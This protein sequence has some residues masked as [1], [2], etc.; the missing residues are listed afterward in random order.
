VL[1]PVQATFGDG[2]RLVG[3]VLEAEGEAQRRGLSAPPQPP[4]VVSLHP[5]ER[6]Y[7]ALFW[8]SAAAVQGDYTAF[9][10]LYDEG[11]RLWGQHDGSPVGDSYPTSR[12]QLGETLVGRYEIPLDPQVPAGAYRLAV[13]MYAST[14]GERLPVEGDEARL[15]GA[16]RVLL[17]RV[18]VE[19]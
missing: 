17:A 18:R 13:G 19:R 5:G 3:Y 6:L 15:M 8:Q 2:I 9:A 11:E 1:S 4:D 12:W 10:H 7:L 14:T 16:E